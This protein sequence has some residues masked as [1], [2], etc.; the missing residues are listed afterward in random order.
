[1]H[2]LCLS[3]NCGKG[4]RGGKRIMAEAVREFEHTAVDLL[5]QIHDAMACLVS[6]KLTAE[7]LTLSQVTV[8]LALH[9]AEDN[10]MSMKKLEK[11]LQVAQSTTVGII[12]RMEQKELVRGLI[13]PR[14]RR[15][16]LVALTDKGRRDADQATV[17]L[18]QIND[19]LGCGLSAEEVQ[20][21]LRV[22][23]G[24]ADR[25]A[26]YCEQRKTTAEL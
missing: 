3:R 6:R 17:F 26:D 11:I 25:L 8:L 1:M 4:E 12:A 14:D 15:V 18:S 2:C 13:D 20:Q 7:D 16:K 24:M 22:L 9:S 19:I 23:Q 5:R 21:N 10:T